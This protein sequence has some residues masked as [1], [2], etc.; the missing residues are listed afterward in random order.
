MARGRSIFPEFLLKISFE[1]VN[2]KPRPT[3][4]RKGFEG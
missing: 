4:I 3:K 1:Y 2:K